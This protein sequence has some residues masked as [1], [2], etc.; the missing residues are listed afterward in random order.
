[1]AR[2]ERLRYLGH[3]QRGGITRMT[4]QVLHSQA[5]NGKQKIGGQPTTDRS[6][7]KDN[8]SMSGIDQKTWQVNAENRQEWRRLVKE[9]AEIATNKWISEEH[10]RRATRTVAELRRLQERTAA[11]EPMTDSVAPG[12]DRTPRLEQLV[13]NMVTT[14]EVIT[15]RSPALIAIP[16]L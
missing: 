11:G 10:A 6:A 2:D 3:V 4:F 12:I 9:V 15:A 8:V 7:V 1:M 16:R 14:T 13:R 5:G